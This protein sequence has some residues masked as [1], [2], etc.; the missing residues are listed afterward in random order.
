MKLY[1]DND[2]LLH[3]DDKIVTDRVVFY[4][5]SDREFNIRYLNESSVLPFSNKSCNIDE[6]LVLNNLGTQ[7]SDTTAIK[8]EVLKFI[9][10]F[11]GGVSGFN[12][13]TTVNGTYFPYIT[14][15]G[16]G[17]RSRFGWRDGNPVWD[18]EVT[19]DG[20]DAGTEDVNWQNVT[21]L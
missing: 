21:G 12:F 5:I 18:A 20:F 9:N 11:S 4:Q 6:V 8:S 13:V 19:V 15:S 1:V 10:N 2:N 17:L 7:Y 3:I 14:D 16:T